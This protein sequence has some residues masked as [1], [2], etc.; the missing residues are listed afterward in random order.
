MLRLAQ[1]D[2]GAEKED[3]VFVIPSKARDLIKGGKEMLRLAQHD[4][5]FTSNE[6]LTRTTS[7]VILSVANDLLKSVQCT[8]YRGVWS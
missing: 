4:N 2:K 5:S 3:R 7:F 6:Q 8:V 1:H